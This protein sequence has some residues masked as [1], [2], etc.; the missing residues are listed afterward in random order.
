MCVRVAPVLSSKAAG[1]LSHVADVLR[2][3]MLEVYIMRL[4]DAGYNT[5][6]MKRVIGNTDIS[7]QRDIYWQ[8]VRAVGKA[9][10]SYCMTQLGKRNVVLLN[11]AVMMEKNMRTHEIAQL[12][13][14]ELVHHYL[15][16]VEDDPDGKRFKGNHNHSIWKILN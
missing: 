4:K 11:L 2:D 14:H 8:G 9:E 16:L 13:F 6:M 3:H 7:I 15:M 10:W 12:I 5:K 1:M